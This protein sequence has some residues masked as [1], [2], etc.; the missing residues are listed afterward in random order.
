MLQHIDL[1]LKIFQGAEDTLL[2]LA[3]FESQGRT[4]GEEPDGVALVA[5]HWLAGFTSNTQQAQQGRQLI[6]VAVHFA[7]VEAKDPEVPPDELMAAVLAIGVDQ[8]Q[9]F[10]QVFI[11]QD[12]PVASHHTERQLAPIQGSDKRTGRLQMITDSSQHSLKKL[13]QVAACQQP[14]FNILQKLELGAVAAKE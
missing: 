5:I 3:V 14:L 9:S 12:G 8:F 13:L 11:F 7:L 2:E 1:R 4:V 10:V 6:T